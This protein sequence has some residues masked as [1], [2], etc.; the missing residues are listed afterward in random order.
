VLPLRF[1]I[2]AGLAGICLWGLFSLLENLGE[3][4]LLRSPKAAVVKGCESIETPD[5]AK[6]CPQFFCQ[7]A[8]LDANTVPRS[9]KFQ[10]TVQ[11]RSDKAELVGGVITAGPA[12]NRHF[13]CM[14]ENN[15][16][17]RHAVLSA[18]ELQALPA[19]SGEWSFEQTGS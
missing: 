5:A 6:L 11:R 17:K 13:A 8:L 14:L 3:P 7:K 1:F 10:I 4:E 2:F 9:S 18:E 16:V 15:V 12:T 19:A